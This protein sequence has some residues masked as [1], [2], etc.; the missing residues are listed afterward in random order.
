MLTL[1]TMSLKDKGAAPPSLAEE[2]PGLI[3]L[4]N[5][6]PVHEALAQPNS[7]VPQ[8]G[9]VGASAEAFKQYIF[10]IIIATPVTVDEHCVVARAV[11]GQPEEFFPT[12]FERLEYNTF[13]KI[14]QRL[15]LVFV[16][17]R[18][19]TAQ[20]ST[21]VSQP[22]QPPLCVLMKVVGGVGLGGVQITVEDLP[23]SIFRK[24]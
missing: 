16:T 5:D 13:R 1:T 2:D 24:P 7:P 3:L 21:T 19:P 23:H 14:M 20:W 17:A 22:P 6:E 9:T 15:R 10:N 18:T 8:G 12:V 11:P 4:Y